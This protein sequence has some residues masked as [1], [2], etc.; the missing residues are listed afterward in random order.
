MTT[1]DEDSKKNEGPCM[2]AKHLKARV[3]FGTCQSAENW[4]DDD[5]EE[6]VC[7]QLCNMTEKCQSW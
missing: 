3:V 2:G 5:N 1:R 7:S 6:Y 4:N